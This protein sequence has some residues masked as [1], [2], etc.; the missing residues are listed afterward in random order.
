MATE[1]I[2]LPVNRWNRVGGKS[3]GTVSAIAV[4]PGPSTDRVLYIGTMSGVYKSRDNGRSW[5]ISNVGLQSPFI[6]NLALASEPGS[7][8]RLFA[9]AGGI[10][11]F[12][13]FGGVN[14]RRLDYWGIKPEI[15]AFAVSPNFAKDQSALTATLSDGIF[16]SDNGGKTWNATNTGLPSGA[17]EVLSVAYSPGFA[18]DQRAYCAVAENGVYR[19]SDGGRNWAACGQENS[20]APAAVQVIAAAPL[21]GEVTGVFFG[22]EDQGVWYSH[23]GGRTVAR[24][25]GIED[26]SVNALAVSPRFASDQTVFAGAGDGAIY[27]SEDAGA[28]FSRVSDPAAGAPVLSLAAMAEP[29]GGSL[30]LAGTYGAGLMRSVDQG[31]SWE[32][33]A[34]GIPSQNW[35]CFAMSPDFGER[36]LM[37]AGGSQGGIFTSDDAGASWSEAAAETEGVP[38][39]QISFSPRF[40][41]DS[42]VFAASAS[43]LFTSDDAG[44]NWSHYEPLGPTELRCVTTSKESGGNYSVFAGGVG[45]RAHLSRNGGREFVRIDHDFRG[46]TLLDVK[47][48]PTFASDETIVVASY[49]S[50]RVVLTQTENGGTSWRRM[51]RHRTA[52]Q[53]SSIVIP[54]SY[55]P[56][57][58]QYWAFAAENQVF[59][60][61]RRFRNVWSGTR[62]A[63][64]ATS[65]LSLT[66]A[67]GFADEPLLFAATSSGAYRSSD[68]GG[69]WHAVNAG[70]DNR[71]VL[72][73]A[74][75]PAFGTDRTVYLLAIG[76]E[77]WGYRDDPTTLE[78]ESPDPTEL[79]YRPDG[80]G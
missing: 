49:G 17:G 4:T 78:F 76:G 19:S 71:A 44:V 27:R 22:D 16:R 20:P 7:S 66:A 15:A 59:K 50:G 40:A 5:T 64:K 39:F 3:G 48:T 9:A 63:N 43:G 8:P 69:T 51:V 33:S 13:S 73:I 80:I 37:L 72:Q 57:E 79:V 36:R 12:M 67:P 75:S 58:N 29:A 47:F 42:R 62:P 21:R 10:G 23:D 70:L 6:Q 32:Y 61:A 38:Y 35:L 28:S 56:V 54:D 52:A 25:A 53:W 65:I 11:G 31:A 24:S 30:L 55:D 18:K 14:W 1:T 26:E 74:A 46:D 34:D 77:I 68:A 2:T 60:P 41:A 45:G